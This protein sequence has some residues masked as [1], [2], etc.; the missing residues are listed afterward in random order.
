MTVYNDPAGPDRPER[1]DPAGVEPARDDRPLTSLFSELATET[2]ALIRKE[3]E[4][5][6]AEL[7]EKAAQAGKGAASLAIG[8]AVAY[9]GV[10]FLLLALTFGLANWLPLWA[11]ALIVGGLVLI[12]GLVMLASGRN[13]LKASNLA[14]NRTIETIKD[15][16]R[17]AK[18]QVGR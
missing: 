10:I 16:G 14:P 12:V 15:D 9:T 17:W 2:S 4:L 5:G 8:G 6:K 11:S 3:I 13:K 7:S 18:A 1:I